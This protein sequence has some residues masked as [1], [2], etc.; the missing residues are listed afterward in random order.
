VLR[1]MVFIT[2]IALM[3]HTAYANK[4]GPKWAVSKEQANSLG[5]AAKAGDKAA[6]VQLQERV[7][8]G[9]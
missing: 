1:F 7:K 3:A 4:L 9:E 5:D 8:L 2:V 6:L